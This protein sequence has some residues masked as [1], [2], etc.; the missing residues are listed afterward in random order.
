MDTISLPITTLLTCGLAFLLLALSWTVIKGRRSLSLSTGDG[1]DS[2]MERRIRAQGNLAE[3]A[4]I[5]V[6]LIALAE[7]QGGNAVVVAILASVFFVGRLAHGYAFAFT[8]KNMKL[9]VRGMM[10]TLFGIS[11]TSLYNLA[12][13]IT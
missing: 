13:L 9:R 1:G 7:L 12:L 2:M 3:Y 10:A 5:F 11:A 6:I 4:P 8:E